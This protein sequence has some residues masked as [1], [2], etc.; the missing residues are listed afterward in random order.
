M[1]LGHCI[2]MLGLLP[3]ATTFSRE[4]SA[5]AQSESLTW[6]DFSSPTDWG[7]FALVNPVEAC[8]LVLPSNVKRGPV[9]R[10]PRFHT[11]F[12]P[13]LY[14]NLNRNKR[15]MHLQYLMAG[16]LPSDYDYFAITA[17][18]CTLAERYTHR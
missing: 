8:K 12:K 1:T 2:P 18:A 3:Q 13:A 10:S 6:V 7:S 15:R 4:L 17:G 9:M 5:L 16:E 11:M 14:A